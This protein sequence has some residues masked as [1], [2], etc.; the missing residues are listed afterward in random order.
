MRLRF[1]RRRGKVG[2][3]GAGEIEM[4]VWSKQHKSVLEELNARGRYAARRSNVYADLGEHAPLVLAAYDWLN[5]HHP[6]RAQRPQDAEG[7]V[8][9]S[10]EKSAAMLTDGQSVLL[11][12][13]IPAERIAP[14]N[15][16]KW[17]AIL[18][19]AYLPRDE[20]DAACHR[21]EMNALG[22]SD[23]QA[24][25]SRFYPEYRR[26]IAESWARLSDRLP[27]PC[28]KG[29]GARAEARGRGAAVLGLA[30]RRGSSAL[31][32]VPCAR[33]AGSRAA[34]LSACVVDAHFAAAVPRRNGEGERGV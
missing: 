19:Y 13:E 30:R 3:K 12:L 25:M 28:G 18:N 32:D 10:Y 24:Y 8:W 1:S 2:E 23:A 27:L 29:R 21:R 9:L 11:E 20:R 34:A 14:V 4:R 5:E 17:G 26:K 33:R 6:L 16:A 22:L 7:L 15:I 31:G